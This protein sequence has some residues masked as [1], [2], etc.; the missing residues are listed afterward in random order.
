MLTDLKYV[1]LNVKAF[2][3]KKKMNFEYR[4][5]S[6]VSLFFVFRHS[7]SDFF[8]SYHAHKSSLAC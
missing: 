1:Y 3:L 4:N 6:E 8:S 5:R 2:T 7:D